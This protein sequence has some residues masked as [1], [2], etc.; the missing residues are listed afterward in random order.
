[1]ILSTIFSYGLFSS[2]INL[3]SAWKH[4]SLSIFQ[5]Y[6]NIIE[7]FSYLDSKI[8]QHYWF[9]Y[10]FV[11]VGL[12]NASNELYSLRAL[13]DISTCW[14]HSSSL[15]YIDMLFSRLRHLM[16]WPSEIVFRLFIVRAARE[17]M[18]ADGWNLYFYR[19]L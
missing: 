2:S 6:F 4:A 18:C 17:F 8:F 7:I 14:N 9:Y 12:F 1:M 3:F 5:H 13:K 15:I 11:I 10:S 19:T 16:T